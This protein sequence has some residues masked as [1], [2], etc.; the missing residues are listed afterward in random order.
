MTAISSKSNEFDKLTQKKKCPWNNEILSNAKIF[1]NV[2]DPYVKFDGKYD[3]DVVDP[4]QPTVLELCPYF[5]QKWGTE[6]TKMMSPQFGDL[7]DPHN[8]Y[9]IKVDWIRKIDLKNWL[10]YNKGTLEI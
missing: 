2:P 6:H 7:K 4:V 3:G 9:I 1:A 10:Y 8:R 5:V